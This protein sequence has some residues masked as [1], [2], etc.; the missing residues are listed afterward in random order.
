MCVLVFITIAHKDSKK[1]KRKPRPLYLWILSS[2]CVCHQKSIL[3]SSEHSN[4]LEDWRDFILFA[5]TWGT[6]PITKKEHHF[7]LCQLPWD[8]LQNPDCG[9]EPQK[10]NEPV[11]GSN[12]DH[13]P[14]EYLPPSKPF[15]LT[16]RQ[17][18]GYMLFLEKIIFTW[19]WGTHLSHASVTGFDLSRSG[20]NGRLIS[21]AVLTVPHHNAV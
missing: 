14:C 8:S 20:P 16:C 13:F 5:Y 2:K 12:C 21:E 10:I 9:E 11:S 17:R 1:K 18:F 3:D 6:W 7:L 15:W 19:I 4:P